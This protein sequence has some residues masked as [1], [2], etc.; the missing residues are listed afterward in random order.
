[1]KHF[2]LRAIPQ[3]LCRASVLLA[4]CASWAYTLSQAQKA[5]ELPAPGQ[6]ADVSSGSDAAQTY[7]MYLPSAYTPAKR[8]PIIYFFDPGGRGRRPVELYKDIAETYGFILAGSNNS[9]NFSSDEGK[10][11][12]AIWQD[13]HSRLA[14]DERRSYASGFSGGARVA[15]M[16]SP[17][18]ELIAFR[19][20]PA[21][22]PVARRWKIPRLGLKTSMSPCPGPPTSSWP[23]ASCRAKVTKTTPFRFWTLNGA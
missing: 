2:W 4:L 17:Q 11:V 5:A 14:L 7:A 13:T 6:I 12:N 15:A 22:V 10:A 23:A 9:R 3:R 8:W 19:L 16:A 20:P 1:M 18:G 21:S